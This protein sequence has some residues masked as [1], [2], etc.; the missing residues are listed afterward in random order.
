MRVTRVLRLLVG[1]LLL[2]PAAGWAAEFHGHRL[3]RA[4]L[5]QRL[6]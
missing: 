6:L 1:S 5:V 4:D 3:D 2:V